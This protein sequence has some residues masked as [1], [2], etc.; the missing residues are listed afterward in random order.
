MS[1]LDERTGQDIYTNAMSMCGTNCR[2]LG[3]LY[4][5]NS[6]MKLMLMTVWL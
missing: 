3:S 2:V 1:G 6:S 5:C 4:W